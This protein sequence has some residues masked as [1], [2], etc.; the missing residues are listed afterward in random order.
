[1]IPASTIIIYHIL[2]LCKGIILFDVGM[3]AEYI[4][5]LYHNIKTIAKK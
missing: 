4:H 2:I 3:V 1:M 5:L